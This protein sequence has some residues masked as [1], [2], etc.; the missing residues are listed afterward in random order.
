MRAPISNPL[1]VHSRNSKDL[2]CHVF[3][4]LNALVRLRCPTAELLRGQLPAELPRHEK[5]K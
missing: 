5:V 2:R 1:L 4:E 3:G